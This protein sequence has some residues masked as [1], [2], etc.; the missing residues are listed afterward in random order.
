MGKCGH[1]ERDS[2]A[3]VIFGHVRSDFHCA[4]RS[5]FPSFQIQTFDS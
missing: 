1:W 3:L 4:R 2:I 5:P